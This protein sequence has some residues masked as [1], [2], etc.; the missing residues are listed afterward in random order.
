MQSG[1]LAVIVIS[2]LVLGAGAIV[3]ASVSEDNNVVYEDELIRIEQ[4]GEFTFKYIAKAPRQT[5][6]L[7]DMAQEMRAQENLDDPPRGGADD[8]AMLALMKNGWWIGSDFYMG[9]VII[10]TFSLQELTDSMR[11]A[12]NDMQSP[13]QL[14]NNERI[15]EKLIHFAHTFYNV[16]YAFD[17]NTLTFV[18]TGEMPQNQLVLL[19]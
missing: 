19:Q 2:L 9:T 5:P 16:G 18:R 6:E 17:L 3:I 7:N 4:L 13:L 15:T 12:D 14:P 11:I 8:A 10:H 1:T